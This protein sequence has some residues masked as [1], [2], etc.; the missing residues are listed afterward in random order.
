[1]PELVWQALDG[2]RS[3][4]SHLVAGPQHVLLCRVITPSQHIF[5]AIED[6]NGKPLGR[7]SVERSDFAA[8][9][10]VSAAMRL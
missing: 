7:L 6:V 4:F 3:E 10:D 8:A 9:D 2:E 5:L 1:L